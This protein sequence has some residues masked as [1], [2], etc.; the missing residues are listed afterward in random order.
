VLKAFSE[1]ADAGAGLA[2]TLIGVVMP[3]A[4]FIRSVAA[5]V[6]VLGVLVFFHELGHYLAARWRG[7][8]VET[9][10]I[11]FGP[12]IKSWTDRRGTVW[13]LA[14]LP[15]GGYV[16]MHGQER[17]QDVSDDVRAT[18]IPGQTFHGKSVLSRAI[19]VAAGPFA[20]FLLAMVMFAALFIAI[21]KPVTVPVIGDVIASSAASRAGL[22]AND[23]IVSIAGEPINT[24][25][26]LQRV[27][28]V[29]PAETLS[30]VIKRDGL[31]QA[32]SVT[33]D[34]RES[35]GHRV[36][37]LGVRGG[38]VEYQQ[39]SLPAAVWGGVTQTWTITRE[40]FSG[41]AQM[42]TGSRGTD[43]LGGPLRIAQLSGQVAKL[44]VAS[45]VSFIAVLSVNLGLINLLPIP[46]LDGG[47][48][49]FYLAEA[50]RGRPLPQ[51][52]LEYGFRAGLAFLACLFVFATWNDLT[53]LGLFRWVAA[54]IG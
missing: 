44:G 52:A 42:I 6:V 22:I 4:G 18:W 30:V 36:G 1:V 11:G 8:H 48:L 51:R 29:H 38:T 7:V 9:F 47:H 2:Q 12:T 40:T 37:Q 46:I 17:P 5:F 34:A 35:G 15:L 54:L 53:Q 10:S 3:L 45:L 33:T 43:E 27:I 25:E 23:R 21:G 50:V 20:N 39:V 32:V 31:D 41:L 28:T 13:K 19:V 14:W 26:D 24:F 49:L 16:K